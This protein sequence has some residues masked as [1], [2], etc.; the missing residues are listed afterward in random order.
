[1]AVEVDP[2]LVER[3]LLELARHGAH[4]ETGVWRT[5]YSPEWVAAQDQVAGWLAEAGLEVRRDAVGSVWGKLAGSEGGPAIATGSHVDSQTPGG[6]YDG[7]L[8]VIG[9]LVALR[10]LREQFGTP[11]RTLEAVSLCEEEASRFHAT[12]FWGS[13]AIVGAISPDEPDRIRDRDGTSIGEAMRSV[14]LDPQRIPE[15][16]RDDLDAWIELHIEQG[17]I[18]ETAGL[19]VGVVDA[20]TAIRHYVV[21]LRGRSDHAGAR[22]MEGRLDPMAGFAEIVT[23]VIGV[24]LDSGAPAV[25]TVGR[26]E[27]EPNL[28]SAVP[29]AVTFTLDSRHP[30]QQ[31][32]D[33]QHAR[34][35]QLMREIAERRGLQI[36]WTK[37]L[38]LPA[39]PSDPAIVAALERA[40]TEEGI[41]FRRMHSGAGHDTQNIAR[42]AKTAMV[43]ARSKDGRSHTPE[44]FTSVEDAVAA[45]RVLA[46]TLH[47]LAY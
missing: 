47:A 34:Q 11:R 12:N 43:F 15:A 18:L 46:A 10:T 38:D 26:V 21:E 33:A 6:R 30:D 40:A 13:R 27:V 28:P 23:A 14:G 37:P 44:E 19:Q 36:S 7:A 32:V 45:I 29:D 1:M 9:G 2:G 35:E 5:V 41:P 4:G 8:G 3:L 24:A 39:C 42:I 25:T 20:I 31:A 22:P 16:R 17:P